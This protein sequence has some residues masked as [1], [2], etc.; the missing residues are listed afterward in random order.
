MPEL[1]EVE[2]TRLGIAPHLEGRTLRHM[3]VRNPNLR[4]PVPEGLA[5]RVRGQPLLK[6]AR[7]GKYL[8]LHFPDGIQLVHLGMSGTLRLLPAQQPPALHDHID[9]HFDDQLLRLRD[10]RRFGAV[11]W[12]PATAGPIEQHPRLASLGIEPFDPRFDARFLQRGIAGRD[13]SIKALL[14]AGNI[15]V[16][17]GNIYASESLFRARIHPNTA[18]RRLSLERCARLVEAVQATLADAIAAGGSSLRD[19][20]HSDGS[21]GYFQ[22]NS[23]VYGRA[24]ETC[25]RCAVGIIR[26]QVQN[27]RA[28]YYCPRCQA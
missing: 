23:A 1:P 17:V 11:L 5:E 6:T 26:K 24:G 18:G 20:V 7:R 21:S 10:P 4:W 15:V 12:H 28:T 25:R 13:A 16:G 14:L 8:L 3:V 22:L 9:W 27:Q 2:V 19:F